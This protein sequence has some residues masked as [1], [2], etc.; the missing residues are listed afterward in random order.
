MHLTLKV[1]LPL[2]LALGLAAP[3][4][5]TEQIPDTITVGS[6]KVDLQSEPLSSYI[7]QNKIRLE[8]TSSANWRGYL[9]EWALTDTGLELKRIFKEEGSMKGGTYTEKEVDISGKVMPGKKLPLLATW[10]S[11]TLVIG[12]SGKANGNMHM[13][14]SQSY[15]RY[16]LV[17]ID[18]G[19]IAKRVDM[20]SDEFDALR[21]KQFQQY[22]T[23]EEYKKRKAEA[24]ADSRKE[25][26]AMKQ[27]DP[28]M[29][30]ILGDFDEEESIDA[31]NYV[32]FSFGM[33]DYL[34]F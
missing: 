12:L 27:K 17:K 24:L 11:G 1:L 9:A 26:E 31:F 28:E 8:A 20:G 6:Q 29:A 3:A 2:C 5:A 22:M 30:K 33:D 23:T 21:K 7:E 10:Y 15:D 16:A 4:V 14:Y 18:K 19:L 25:S 13:G 34:K 32:L